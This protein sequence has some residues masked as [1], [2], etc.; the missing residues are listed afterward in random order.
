MTLIKAEPFTGRTHQI[1]VHLAHINHPIVGDP[2]YGAKDGD[3]EDYLDGRMD[4]LDRERAFGNARMLLHANSLRFFY[5]G[6]EYK[7]VADP[8]SHLKSFIDSAN[9]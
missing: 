2:L 6:V 5:G 8:I 4:D 3:S 7:I 1:R 9:S